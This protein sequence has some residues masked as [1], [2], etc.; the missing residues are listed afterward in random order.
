MKIYR[1][2]YTQGVFD[3][4]HIGHL[5]LLNRAKE[6]CEFLVVG[7]NS[8]DLVKSYKNKIPVIAQAER[9]SIVENIKAVDECFIARTLDKTE[10]WKRVKF[11]AVFIGGDWKGNERWNQTERKLAELGA[12]VVYLPYTDGISST[13]LKNEKINAITETEDA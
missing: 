6:M 3:M 2:G 4:F 1:I 9:K 8:D 7:V 11:D 5:N 13:I 10:I 12:K